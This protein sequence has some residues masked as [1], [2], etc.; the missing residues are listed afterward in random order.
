MNSLDIMALAIIGI[1]IVQAL[2]K[3]LAAELAEIACAIAGLLCALLFFE[4]IEMILLK[5]GVGN[6]MAAMLGFTSIF[7]VFIVLGTFGSLQIKK[8]IRKKRLTWRDRF[9]GV[10][11]GLIRG[12]VINSVIFM[13][14]LVFPV[15]PPL[16]KTS[17]TA[18][19]FLSGLKVVKLVAPQNFKN[20]IPD[21]KGLNWGRPP[22]REQEPSDKERD[23]GGVPDENTI[24]K[25]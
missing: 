18:S 24:E 14:L 23:E 5:I 8:A 12:F 25:I 17:F 7:L 10:P 6:P 11:L 3:G 20:L 2:T 22:G 16:I 9:W 15:N 4:N 21:E 1:V 13:V 19:F